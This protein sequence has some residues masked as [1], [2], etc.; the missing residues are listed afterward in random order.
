ML[1][2]GVLAGAKPMRMGEVYIRLTVG[3][4]WDCDLLWMRCFL[5]D[6]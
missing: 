1:D 4:C 6:V 3:I 2:D 5:D